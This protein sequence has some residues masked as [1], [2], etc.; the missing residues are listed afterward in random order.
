MKWNA[1]DSGLSAASGRIDAMRDLPVKWR[2]TG[3]GQSP[4][5]EHRFP[6]V[7]VN[8]QRIKVSWSEKGWGVSRAAYECPVCR[9]RARYLY[10]LANGFAC[11]R[12]VTAE[13]VSLE[14]SLVDLERARVLK[15][16]GKHRARGR[17]L[18]SAALWRIACRRP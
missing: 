18:E 14:R 4:E 17:R 5:P 9:R 16:S 12:H 3:L 8:G 15:R 6:A 7:M 13:R 2:W 10:A 1:L 11:N